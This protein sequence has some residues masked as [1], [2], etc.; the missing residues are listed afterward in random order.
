MQAKNFLRQQLNR[1][2]LGLEYY[3]KWYANWYNNLKE[4]IRQPLFFSVTWV[5]LLI[6]LVQK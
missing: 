2:G 5:F 6:G 4:D 3:F 1:V